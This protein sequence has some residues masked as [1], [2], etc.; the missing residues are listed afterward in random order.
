MNG[1]PGK[2][3]V[4]RRGLRQ[5]DP[6]SPMLFILVMDVL[7]HM[8]SKATEMGLLQPL[9]RRAL[10]QHRISLY[11]DDAVLF[12]RPEAADIQIAMDILQLFGEASGL[13]TNLQKSNVLPIRCG[14][15]EIRVLQQHLPCEIT[16]FPCKY[17]GLPLSLKKLSRDNIQPI[18]D[19]IADQL[20]GWKA[21]LIS[22][23]GQKVHVQF[24]LT[25]KMVYLAM[26]VDLPQWAHKAVN[27]IRR[28]YLWRGRTNA[29]G[30][31]CLV[32]WDSVCRPLELGGLGI[33]NLTTLGWALRVRW[34]W[35]QKTQPQRPWSSLP[36]QMPEQARAFFSVAM[37]SEVGNGEHTIFWT[38]RWLHGR[39]IAELAPCLH[40]G[41]PKRKAKSRTVQE[42]LNNHAWV[43][44]FSGALSV[45]VM[46]E[47]LQL[48]DFLQEV[49]LQPDVEDTHLWRLSPTGQYSAKSHMEAYS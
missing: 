25:S 35:L 5:G 1:I 32:A 48:W 49:T 43:S 41:I 21:D 33:S 9:S 13:Q 18:I 38:D 24:V 28:G 47:Y 39:S 26:A 44:D 17:M 12:L 22:R 40:A 4:H 29:K 30:G 37:A 34:L 16:D 2:R 20:P 23:A 8:V 45:G 6:L 11:A 27:K 31:H 15:D 7:S 14:D 10:L 19:S 36:I 46:V 3:I 42:A